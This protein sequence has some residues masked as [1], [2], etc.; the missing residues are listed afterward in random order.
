MLAGGRG[1]ADAVGGSTWVLVVLVAVGAVLTWAF[2]RDPDPPGL[3][4]SV[5]GE[6]APED[7]HRHAHHRR[8]HL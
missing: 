7:L 5:A 1:F 3:D 4:P 6:P 2:V 8:F